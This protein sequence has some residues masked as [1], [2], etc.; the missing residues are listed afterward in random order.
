[1]W[2]SS[3]DLTATISLCLVDWQNYTQ[4]C[5]RLYA[6]RADVWTEAGNAHQEDDL[7][8]G[9]DTLGEQDELG[10]IIDD[11]DKAVQKKN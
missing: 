10:R 5:D 8:I 11:M 3:R 9:S 6:N 7:L 4:F 2:R 1:M